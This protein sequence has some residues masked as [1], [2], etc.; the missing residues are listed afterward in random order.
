MRAVCWWLS[1]VTSVPHACTSSWSGCHLCP[2]A[3]PLQRG[4]VASRS[5]PVPETTLPST[6]RL[7]LLGNH[8]QA[9]L[10]TRQRGNFFPTADG[11][12]ATPAPWVLVSAHLERGSQAVRLAAMSL[13]S[14]VGAQD[15]EP[16]R[17]RFCYCDKNLEK[18]AWRKE[19]SWL[20]FQVSVHRWL[21]LG[22]EPGGAGG[23]GNLLTS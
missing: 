18:T 19:L 7:H 2:A 11:F 21:A 20:M 8:A 15:S 1:G 9:P 22:Q 16:A 12:S 6:R 23:R 4:A 13:P 5:L 14:H 17:V 3:C 10:G